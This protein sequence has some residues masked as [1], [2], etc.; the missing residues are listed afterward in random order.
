MIWVKYYITPIHT[1]TAIVKKVEVVINQREA[2]I[3]ITRVDGGI[4]LLAF[5]EGKPIEISEERY[6][7]HSVRGS[8]WSRQDTREEL[9]NRPG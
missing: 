4:E 3:K 6:V 9:K 2:N 1:A 8:A 7:N 5:Y